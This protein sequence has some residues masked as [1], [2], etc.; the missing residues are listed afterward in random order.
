MHAVKTTART[1]RPA[2]K[3]PDQRVRRA[4]RTRARRAGGGPLSVTV[5]DGLRRR[6][7]Q[8]AK[9]RDLKLATAARVLMAERLDELDEA[10]VLRKAEEWQR[11]QAWATWERFKAGDRREVSWGQLKRDTERALER[12]RAKARSK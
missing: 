7:A 4:D 11:E 3:R 8:Q 9:R 12:A 5:S 6:L 2:R 10:E 1:A